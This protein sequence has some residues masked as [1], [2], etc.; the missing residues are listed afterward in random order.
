MPL[1][2][3]IWE[4]ERFCLE[5]GDELRSCPIVEPLAGRG[6]DAI[7]AH[8]AL[9]FCPPFLFLE[10]RVFCAHSQ[11][12]WLHAFSSR[13]ANA[14]RSRKTTQPRSASRMTRAAPWCCRG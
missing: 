13:D 6:R 14:N 1:D 10:G 4:G 12:F 5:P 7:V 2:R 9:P 3:S 11:P 8:N